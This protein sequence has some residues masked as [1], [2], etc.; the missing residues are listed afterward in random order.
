MFTYPAIQ[1]AEKSDSV[2]RK[3]SRFRD[4]NL[5]CAIINRTSFWPIRITFD[6]STKK[7]IGVELMS[8][9]MNIPEILTSKSKCFQP[10]INQ[11]RH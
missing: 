2:V 6:L 4:C 10:Y 11:V 7:T 3:L 8:G 9:I 5:H 1:K